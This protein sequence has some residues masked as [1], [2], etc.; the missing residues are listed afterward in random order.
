MPA[1][2]VFQKIWKGYQLSKTNQIREVDKKINQLEF[3]FNKEIYDWNFSFTPSHTQSNL[4]SLYSFQS[5]NT[6]TDGLT[7]TFAKSSY[8]MGTFSFEH[9]N[10]VY[11]ISKWD[12]SNAAAFGSDKIYEAKNTL[13]YSYEFLDKSSQIDLDLVNHGFKEK[14]AST[15]HA[16]ETDYYEFFQA[17]LQTKLQVYS[18][19]LNQ[20]FL[21][22]S[23]KRVRQ[24]E[25]R[26]RDGISRKVE[27][28][29]AKS[30]EL[31]QRENLQS[32]RSVL[33]QNLAIIE[34]LIGVKI[35]D[36][37]FEQLTWDKKNFSFWD[38]N[39]DKKES[40]SIAALKERIKKS[41]AN[42]KKVSH[43]NGY[44]LNLS[45]SYSSNAFSED[46]YSESLSESAGSNTKQSLLL[47]FTIPLG[48]DKFKALQNKYVAQ[49]SKNELELFNLKDQIKV[50]KEALLEQIQF[51][52]SAYSITKEK[53]SLA[54]ATLAAQNKLYL[55][56]QA[57]FNEV[58]LA[59]ESYLQA[60]LTEK[61]LLASLELLVGNYAYLNGSIVNF[62]N[63]YVD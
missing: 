1:K 10:L 28:L 15:N 13:T 44:K 46:S 26:N 38:R 59:E 36:D 18:L 50:S 58:I 9:N 49:R 43:S 31:T 21:Q 40:L 55:R 2:A 42:L 29:Q 62:L 47:T 5:Q 8:G 19:R 39:I 60:V 61:K 16:Q 35:T 3:E 32:T 33:K 12:A 52:D 27:L 23:Q 41:E 11:D 7:F 14:Q 25:K 63:S 37:Y 4:A 56:G 34:N 57:T 45:A 22:R 30:S 24:I 53:I 17:Y 6:L 51:L 48:Q 20:E 54:K